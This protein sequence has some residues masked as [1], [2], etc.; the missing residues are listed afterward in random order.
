MIP[1]TIKI[2]GHIYDCAA[3][4]KI[5]RDSNSLGNSCGNA[6]EIKIDSTI[7]HQNQQSTLLHEILE[8]ISYRYELC[9]EHSKITVLETALFQ[10]MQDNPEAMK[11]I[12]KKV[13]CG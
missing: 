12:M 7:P 5:T 11:F 4:D 2:G 9:L 8:Q 1:E 13:N 10:V 6:L 3:S